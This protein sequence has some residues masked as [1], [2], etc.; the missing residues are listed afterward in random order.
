MR[1]QDYNNVSV[2]VLDK[3]NL[4]FDKIMECINTVKSDIKP[5]NTMESIEAIL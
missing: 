2:I 4:T 1:V 3:Y 5:L